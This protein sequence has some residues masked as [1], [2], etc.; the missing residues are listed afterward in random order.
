M[1]SRKQSSSGKKT[2]CELQA[3]QIRGRVRLLI[4]LKVTW[5]ARPVEAAGPAMPF[6]PT[7]DE[8]KNLVFADTLS[9]IVG[10]DGS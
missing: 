7:T 10:Y 6:A 3:R 4:L 1:A 8:G 9:K 5:S 2:K